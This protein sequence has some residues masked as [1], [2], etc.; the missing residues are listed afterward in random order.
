M[1]ADTTRERPAPKRDT[2]VPG[3][4]AIYV[5]DRGVDVWR[6]RVDLEDPDGDWRF[7]ET[8]GAEDGLRVSLELAVL[9]PP[10][11]DGYWVYSRTYDCETDCT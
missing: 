10:S 6:Y 3:S 7:V 5:D 11:E 4:Y 8:H 1:G 9:T 2:V